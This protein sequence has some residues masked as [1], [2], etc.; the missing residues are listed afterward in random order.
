MNQELVSDFISNDFI[1]SRVMIEFIWISSYTYK[2][3]VR[4]SE[5]TYRHPFS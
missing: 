3:P 1:R 5:L 4:G 2:E